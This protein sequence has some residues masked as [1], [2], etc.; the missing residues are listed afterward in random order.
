MKTMVVLIFLISLGYSGVLKQCT[1][2]GKDLKLNSNKTVKYTLSC[3]DGECIVYDYNKK[4]IIFFEDKIRKAE[5]LED[6]A[7]LKRVISLY[8]NDN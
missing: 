7:N 1:Y 6:C 4:E 8:K 3:Q 5:K 2:Q